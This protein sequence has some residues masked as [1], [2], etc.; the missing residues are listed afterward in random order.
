MRPQQG[1]IMNGREVSFEEIQH[2][3]HGNS[4]QEEVAAK[5]IKNW[6]NGASEFN[7]KT[8]GSTGTPK[9]II[10]SRTQIEHS[11]NQTINFLGL[12]SS[13]RAFVCINTAYI[14][15]TM[16]FARA[17][18]LGM[19]I[20]LIEPSSDPFASIEQ[21][22]F[23][24]LAPLQLEAIVNNPK[25]FDKLSKAKAAL[26]GGAPI[27][28]ALW[29]NLAHFKLPIFQTYGMT[30]TV[31]HIALRKIEGSFN[32]PYMAFPDVKLS[33]EERGCLVIESPVTNHLPV[34]TNDLVNLLDLHHFELIGRVDN[35]I[36]SGGIKLHPEIIESKIQQALDFSG[37]ELE[38]YITSKPHDKLGQRVIMVI[39]ESAPDVDLHL[40]KNHLDKFEIPKKI[41]RVASIQR[42]D[43]G[44]IKRK[45]F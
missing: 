7:L 14:G 38:F 44:K 21:T 16:M 4:D 6:L 8:S 34:V 24:A 31:S 43:S 26:I 36:N 23:V 30:E 32:A 1:V 28:E 2:D 27:N 29:N 35:V 19:E 22:D 12:T 13:S 10:I 5:F 17:L 18:I 33:V 11:A 45:S 37:I 41:V 15:G 20:T 25:S 40:F 42:T 3:F 39:E 9:S